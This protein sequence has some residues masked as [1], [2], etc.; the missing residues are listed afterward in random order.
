MQHEA[1][2]GQRVLHKRVKDL[3]YAEGEKKHSD[4]QVYRLKSCGDR[5]REISERLLDQYGW[6][7]MAP[8]TQFVIGKQTP[9]RVKKE[10]HEIFG[11]RVKNTG[12]WTR[13]EG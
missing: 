12:W 7:I 2:E 6:Y 3:I 9:G 10:I 4:L 11:N 1:I 8:G 13:C 5:T